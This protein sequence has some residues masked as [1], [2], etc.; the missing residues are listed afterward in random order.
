MYE[1]SLLHATLVA[2]AVIFSYTLTSAQVPD[3]VKD[4]ASKTKD[5]SVKTAKK[6]TDVVND[7]A[8]K[9]VDKTKD[10]VDATGDTAAK[11]SKATA[12][13]SRQIG[14][15]TVQTTENVTE[16]APAKVKGEG[17][18]LTT[19]TWDGSKWVAKRA[20]YETKK[21]T[22]STKDAVTGSERPRP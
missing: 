15:Y 6:T 20:W 4:A 19:T 9:A 8:D 14:N 11:T 21:D 7:S 17:R 2:A 5:V 10:V 16:M 22:R 1:K 13:K 12:S 18:W 3:K